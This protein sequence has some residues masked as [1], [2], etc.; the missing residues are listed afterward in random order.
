MPALVSSVVA[1]GGGA[2]ARLCAKSKL[3]N[4]SSESSE[5]KLKVKGI[6]YNWVTIHD[7]QMDLQ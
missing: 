4:N 1:P 5:R 3:H 6:M 2:Q 7:P